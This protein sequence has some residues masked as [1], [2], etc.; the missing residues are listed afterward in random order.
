MKKKICRIGSI[1]F[2]L[3]MISA[4]CMKINKSK[5][6]TD[7][8]GP[9]LPVKSIV[10]TS[11]VIGPGNQNSDTSTKE[12]VKGTGIKNRLLEIIQSDGLQIALERAKS[13]TGSERSTGVG[14]VLRMAISID[15]DF[16]SREIS[17][18]G[19]EEAVNDQI[20]Q[21]LMTGWPDIERAFEWATRVLSGDQRDESISVLIGRITKISPRKAID[22]VN[23]MLPGRARD[24][25]FISMV[26]SWGRTDFNSAMGFVNGLEDARD[27]ALA[28]GS[29]APLWAEK[30][31]Q[32]AMKHISDA[33][34]DDN[35]VFLAHLIAVKRVKTDPAGTLAWA[36]SMNGAAADRAGRSAVIIWTHEDPLAASNYISSMNE[37]LKKKYAPVL[38]GAWAQI[39]PESAGVW[40]RSCQSSELQT[41]TT[42]QLLHRWHEI[43]AK[44]AWQWVSE[45]PDGPVKREGESILRIRDSDHD[46]GQLIKKFSKWYEDTTSDGMLFGGTP[47][48]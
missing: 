16:V 1:V 21:K 31:L 27:R 41:E 19:L 6:Q 30:D 32:S 22:Y 20:L 45:L 28:F 33:P 8:V 34:G 40:V 26:S 24:R 39:D 42:I 25:T 46:L 43:S 3:L 9:E 12:T 48:D 35:S 23:V 4:V 14:F 7:P 13:L 37:A 38:I 47:V 5:N 29:L 44:D 18:S 11:V 10:Q 17:N 2:M 15:P 36:A